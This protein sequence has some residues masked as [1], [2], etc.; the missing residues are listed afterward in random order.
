MSITV[1]ILKYQKNPKRQSINSND[2][3]CAC[4]EIIR[5]NAKNTIVS[6]IHQ[7]PKR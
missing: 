2:I 4:I 3:E 1:L 6:C 7:P 5:K